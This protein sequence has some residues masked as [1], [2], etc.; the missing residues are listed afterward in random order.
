MRGT[1]VVGRSAV[2]AMPKGAPG[3]DPVPSRPAP[4]CSSCLDLRALIQDR[5]ILVVRVNA[6]PR[7]AGDLAENARFGQI[8]D[9]VVDGRFGD[10]QC[11]SSDRA[12]RMTCLIAC[13]C[14]LSAVAAARRSV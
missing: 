7:A 3:A 1:R 8:P 14:R 9:G 12:L 2:P 11:I 6:A 13:S 4:S 5:E 10:A